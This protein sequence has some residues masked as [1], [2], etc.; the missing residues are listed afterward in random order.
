MKL[1]MIVLFIVISGCASNKSR[2]DVV[3]ERHASEVYDFAP[4]SPERI[5]MGVQC[6][7]RLADDFYVE[8]N[9]QKLSGTIKD[10]KSAKPL[11]ERYLAK[12]AIRYKYGDREYAKNYQI[13]NGVDPDKVM[14][15]YEMGLKISHDDKLREIMDQ[16]YHQWRVEMAQGMQ[17][18]QGQ[19]STPAV[20][21]RKKLDPPKMCTSQRVGNSVDTICH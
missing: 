19:S 12:M 8:L 9:Q 1:G 5:E 2:R 7:G 3:F 10:E 20:F 17:S 21:Q 16:E 14:Y 11:I 18:M 15:L 4:C 13:A 6:V